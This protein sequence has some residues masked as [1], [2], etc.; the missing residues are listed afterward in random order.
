[1]SVSPQ[2]A[3]PP[4]GNDDPEARGTRRYRPGPPD[5]V[6]F[7]V[8]PMLDMAFQLLAFFILTF[9]APTAETHIEL[10][11]PTTPAALPTAARGL[12]RPTSRTVDVDLE[13]DVLIRAEADDLGDLKALRLGEAPVPDLAQLGQRLR[14]YVELLGNRPLRVRLIADDRLLYEP[15]A[16][17]IAV[18][19]ASGVAA[20]RLAP[21]GTSP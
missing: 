7:P 2:L 9:R 20:V 8:A 17:I 19:S 4:A 3:I 21:P 10:Y 5:D 16:R 11:L 6:Y 1:M 12:A 14:R 18:C 13:N 15:A